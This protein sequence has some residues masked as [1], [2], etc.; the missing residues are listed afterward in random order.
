MCGI[1]GVYLKEPERRITAAYAVLSLAMDSRGGESWGYLKK[2]FDSEDFRLEKDIGP[3]SKNVSAF[4]LED[5]QLLLAHSR[6]AT[7]GDVKKENSHPFK[8]GEVV[9]CHNGG[10][11]NW[12]ELNKKFDRNFEVDSMHIFAHLNEDKDLDDLSG[13][14]TIS[15]VDF[16]N[17]PETFVKFCKFNG[18]SLA[19]A[20]LLRKK[21]KD[22]TENIIGV[23]WA[24]TEGALTGALEVAGIPYSIKTC[25][26][27][28]L[29]YVPKSDPRIYVD[30]NQKM[31][32]GTFR[33]VVKYEHRTDQHSR[34]Y[35]QDEDDIVFKGSDGKWHPATK[36]NLKNYL[37][38]PKTKKKDPK[39]DKD[40]EGILEI[41]EQEF[42]TKSTTGV[43]T[44]CKDEAVD[45]IPC[46][47]PLTGNLLCKTCA[48]GWE[49]TNQYD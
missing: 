40:K 20:D 41:V 44:S 27:E 24:S 42:A 2:P 45:V 5:A 8:F 49:Y 13:W 21:G 25:D 46:T 1:F 29:Y 22:T 12:E 34:I 37:P 32:L 18:G 19:F 31:R 36:V 23:A 35:H 30:K 14:G 9:G 26:S 43:C 33:C 38:H 15:W 28:V 3:L 7:V 4:D 47:G 6:S 39:S 10:I 48:V 16:R 17:W 11:S